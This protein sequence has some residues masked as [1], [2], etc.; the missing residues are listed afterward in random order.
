MNA[1]VPRRALLP[2][3]TDVS[4]L[5]P[6]Q[7]VSALVLSAQMLLHLVPLLDGIELWILLYLRLQHSLAGGAATGLSTVEA[8]DAEISAYIGCSDRTLRRWRKAQ[9]Q[10]H[11]TALRV[12]VPVIEQVIE[13]EDQMP[14][15]SAFRY[16]FHASD[17]ELSESLLAEARVYASRAGRRS[18]QDRLRDATTAAASERIRRGRDPMGQNVRRA[19]RRS[20]QDVRR[21][22]PGG[23]QDVRRGK[24]SGGQ[25]V[26]PSGGRNVLGAAD[27]MSV[28]DHDNQ[29]I[30]S[31]GDH[32]HDPYEGF[33]LPGIPPPTRTE[34]ERWL[35]HEVHRLNGG[36]A[37]DPKSYFAFFKWWRR[38]G[39][40]RATEAT[41]RVRETMQQRRLADPLA[42]LMT[43]MKGMQ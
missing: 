13:Y 21:E 14:Y 33:A 38:V 1:P 32:D 16:T 12:L 25:L 22:I 10:E 20:G 6:A 5:L 35:W 42:Y 7:P 17:P 8:T 34:Y 41:G 29:G 15:V 23:G 3:G 4:S 24:S 36:R 11:R 19:D 26:R 39:D 40:G 37:L 30:S 28:H 18:F 31:H 9:Y 2:L 43:T 27:G